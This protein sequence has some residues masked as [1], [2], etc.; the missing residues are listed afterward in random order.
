MSLKKALLHIYG[1]RSIYNIVNVCTLRALIIQMFDEIV[2]LI[3][4]WPKLRI[5]Y[6]SLNL[7]RLIPLKLIGEFGPK[8]CQKSV[9]SWITRFCKDFL[10]NYNI[11]VQI[12]ALKI[13]SVQCYGVNWIPFFGR[14][15]SF[16]CIYK[17]SVNSLD[18]LHKSQS[19]TF[20]KAKS[21]VILL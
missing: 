7:Q 10:E 8:R 15:C 5:F 12:K 20:D 17:S 14:Q 4:F 13:Q 21:V 18:Q 2:F 11:W 3:I 6:V 9:K 19:P 16:S 1:V